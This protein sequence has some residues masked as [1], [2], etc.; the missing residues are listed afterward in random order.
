MLEQKANAY[1]VEEL[2]AGIV[3]KSKLRESI[4]KEFVNTIYNNDSY[5]NNAI[6]LGKILKKSGSY[7][8]ATR[9]ILEYIK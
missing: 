4:L 8:K 7:K 6:R 2:G 3:Y 5:R 1:R 9:L